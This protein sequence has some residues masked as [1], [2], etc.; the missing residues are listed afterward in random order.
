[1]AVAQRLVVRRFPDAEIGIQRYANWTPTP[2]SVETR[3]CTDAFKVTVALRSFSIKS[4]SFDHGASIQQPMNTAGVLLTN[5][6][7]TTSAFGDDPFDAVYFMLPQASLD[8]IALELDGRS[9]MLFEEPTRFIAQDEVLHAL[10]LAMVPALARPQEANRLFMDHLSSAVL[11]HV[12]G[13]YGPAE[14]APPVQG[15]LAPWQ[16]RRAR[17]FLIEN[18]TGNPSLQ[19]LA[20]A[21]GLSTAHFSRSFRISTGL[22]PHRWLLALRVSEAKRLLTMTRAPLAAIAAACGFADQSHFTRTFTRMA[23]MAPGKW[24]QH[25][26]S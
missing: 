16:L 19:Q 9:R 7:Y 6:R 22:P 2:V 24:R 5:M 10:A 1:M 13:C 15:G 12:L 23:G 4:L 8:A 17:E 26:N 11:L 20:A 3:D 14:P 18:M 21:C 25:R